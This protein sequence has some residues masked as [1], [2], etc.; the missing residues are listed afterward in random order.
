MNPHVHLDM[1]RRQVE[2]C[3][4]SKPRGQEVCGGGQTS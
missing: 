3:I 1:T 2:F 4:N